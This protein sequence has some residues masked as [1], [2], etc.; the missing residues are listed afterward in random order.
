MSHFLSETKINSI[1]SEHWHPPSF[2]R[3]IKKAPD[4]P[5]AAS[6]RI[7]LQPGG[8]HLVCGS[9]TL[10]HRIILF[11]A[12]AGCALGQSAGTFTRREVK[13]ACEFIFGCG[14]RAYQI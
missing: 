7:R 9:R 6:T 5:A 2:C 3:P 14:L 11:S 4:P 12:A 13:R 1:D 8:A 10:I